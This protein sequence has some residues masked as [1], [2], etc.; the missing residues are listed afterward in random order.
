MQNPKLRESSKRR[1]PFHPAGIATTPAG[2]NIPIRWLEDLQQSEEQVYN[3]LRLGNRAPC[4]VLGM[5]ADSSASKVW[6]AA[7]WAGVSIG[8]WLRSGTHNLMDA[9]AQLGGLLMEQPIRQLVESPAGAGELSQTTSHACPVD[10]PLG[11]LRDLPQRVYQ[12]RQQDP[13]LWPCLT[14]CWDDPYRLP[15]V[16]WQVS[17]GTDQTG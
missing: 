4:L 13:S 5:P 3:A 1:W 9:R 8:L 2:V 14:L 11:A 17:P 16:G 7:V 10:L 6:R 15:P 12:A